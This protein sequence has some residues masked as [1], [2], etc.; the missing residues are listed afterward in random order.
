MLQVQKLK[1]VVV[2]KLL[3][4]SDDFV[5]LH[6]DKTVILACYV[7]VKN[8]LRK[9]GLAISP[10]KTRLTHTLELK[11]TDVLDESFDGTVGFN[12]LGFTIKQFKSKYQSAKNTSFR[13]QNT[14]LPYRFLIIRIS[15]MI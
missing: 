12:F 6:H 8:W 9:V 15:F 1:L 2:E 5:I 11:E 3:G 4:Q 10:S 7:E 13:I 14:N